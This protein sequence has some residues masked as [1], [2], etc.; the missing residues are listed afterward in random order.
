MVLSTMQG[1]SRVIAA[2][3]TAAVTWVEPSARV[4]S[5]YDMHTVRHSYDM[6]SW[7]HVLQKPQAGKVSFPKKMF[8]E[9]KNKNI[10]ADDKNTA[11]LWGLYTFHVCNSA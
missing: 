7:C 2:I 6:M 9:S 1:R 3:Q 11:L 4:F 5:W 8:S 10:R